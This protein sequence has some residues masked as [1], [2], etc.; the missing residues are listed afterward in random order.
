MPRTGRRTQAG[1]DMHDDE[2]RRKLMG[3]LAPVG[4]HRTHQELVDWLQVRAR[5]ADDVFDTLREMTREGTASFSGV[6]GPNRVWWL[7]PHCPVRTALYTA[8]EHAG[9]GHECTFAG[10]L[11]DHTGSCGACRGLPS[12]VREWRRGRVPR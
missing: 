9:L 1:A 11:A 4:S 10:L 2:L 12:L 6:A 7:L 5:H 3:A 8:L